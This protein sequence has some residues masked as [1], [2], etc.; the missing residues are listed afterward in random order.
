MHHVYVVDKK[1]RPLMPTIR[2]GHVRKLL[3][4][5]KAV[6]ISHSPFTIRLKYDVPGFPAFV[7]IDS[8]GKVLNE[9]LGLNPF[10]EALKK[11][12]PAEE[13]DKLSKEYKQ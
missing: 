11:Y 5:C 9:C 10:L 4:E 1:G 8:D 6:P 12:I 7:I 13:V 3:K 2:F